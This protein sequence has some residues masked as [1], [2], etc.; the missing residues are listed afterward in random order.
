MKD[1]LSSLP[2]VYGDIRR[3]YERRLAFAQEE[4]GDNSDPNGQE[5]Q[6]AYHSVANTLRAVER[7]TA[8]GMYQRG[9]I[10]DSVLHILERELDLLDIRFADR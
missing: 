10:P 5:Y 6:R 7:K 1:K 4:D 9:E 2:E 8:I 3:Y